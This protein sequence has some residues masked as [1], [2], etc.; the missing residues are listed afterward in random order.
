MMLNDVF[1]ILY[2]CWLQVLVMQ[3]SGRYKLSSKNSRGRGACVTTTL[4]SPVYF[5]QLT[6]L[7]RRE[8][9]QKQREEAEK[10]G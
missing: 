6:P 5:G 7:Y 8:E 10:Q 4:I 1:I 3:I 9:L 2:R